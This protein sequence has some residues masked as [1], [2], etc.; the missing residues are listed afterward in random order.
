MPTLEFAGPACSYGPSKAESCESMS[1]GVNAALSSR[2]P[3][4]WTLPLFAGRADR[5]RH[6]SR[7]RHRAR[8]LGRIDP[9]RLFGLP[10]RALGICGGG[11]LRRLA[12]DRAV[13]LLRLQSV[14]DLTPAKWVLRRFD[15]AAIYLLIAGTYTPFLAQLDDTAHGAAD[16]RA[17]C[18]ARR[19]PASRSSCF[20]PGRFDRL[21][22]VFYLAIGWSGVSSC[23]RC[24]R[25]AAADHAVAD[26]RRRHRLFRRRRLLR[27]AAAAL[28]ERGLARFVV[29]GAGLHLAAV[30]DCLVI[31]RL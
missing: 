26:R 12:A 5:R 22:V 4:L 31:N 29:L 13:D 19:R 15:H 25:H 30:M 2:N 24:L 1:N 11:L 10:H 3:V 14:A 27:L 9:A 8:D 6:R 23:G 21:A 20:L 18:G 28:P 16:A 17:S 7:S